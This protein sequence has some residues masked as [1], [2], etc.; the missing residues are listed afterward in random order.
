MSK[1]ALDI[2]LVVCIVGI[3]IFIGITSLVNRK[4]QKKEREKR[5]REVRDKIKSFIKERENKKNLYIEFEKVVARK[6]KKYKTRD[7]FE[8]II[9]IF[10]AKTRE[11]IEDRAY[12]I[13]GIS[14]PIDKKNYTHEWVINSRL[15]IENTRHRISII[16]GDVKL[17]K[18][19]KKRQKQLAK[20]ERKQQ[21][22]LEKEERKKLRKSNESL[23]PKKVE[24]E[25]KFIPK[26]DKKK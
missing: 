21:Y 14:I 18:D 11:H 9:K 15:D 17:S 8:V 25:N 7:V 2:I 24:H 26:R 6:G 12:E 10:D 1:Y 13:E 5:K 20:E 22:I 3:I 23:K 19:E 4:S 16:E